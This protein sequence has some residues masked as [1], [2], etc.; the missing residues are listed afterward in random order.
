MVDLWMVLV[1][2]RMHQHP[3]WSGGRADR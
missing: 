1:T 2:A 3:R